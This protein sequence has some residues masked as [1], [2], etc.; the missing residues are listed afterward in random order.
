METHQ[1]FIK[2]FFASY[3]AVQLMACAPEDP[4]LQEQ[5]LLDTSS[6]TDT[7]EDELEAFAETPSHFDLQEEVAKYKE[8][9]K[10]TDTHSKI[11]DNR[12][13]GPRSLYGTRNVR[14]VLHGVMYR[15]GANNRYFH[16]RRSNINPLPTEG[17]KNLCKNDFSTA[18]YLYS[19][20][21]WKAPR[22]VS[23]R[24][25]LDEKSLKYKQYAA[26]GENKK[27]LNLIYLRIKGRLDG[28]VYTHCWN[29]WHSS[30]LIAA[31]ALKQFCGWNNSRAEAYWRKNTDGNSHGYTRLRKRLRDFKPYAEYKIS[32]KEKALICPAE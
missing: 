15:G 10:V 6:Q 14:V 7:S 12:G 30:G 29:G 28:P 24:N 18:I 20:N 8:R 31:M 17:L 22:A 1:S 9:F 26:A 2:I 11:I 19:E 27:I 4:D 25:T 21:Y 5:D 16:K 3:V 23:C 13:R 32:S